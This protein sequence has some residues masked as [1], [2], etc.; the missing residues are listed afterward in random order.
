M[1]KRR[2]TTLHE[3]A[4]EAGRAKPWQDTGRSTYRKGA[5]VPSKEGMRV[6]HRRH[7]KISETIRE[8]QLD[9]LGAIRR[10]LRSH[11]GQNWNKVWSKLCKELGQGVAAKHI[12]DHVDA[13]VDRY[14]YD[15]NG[16]LIYKLWYYRDQF[17]VDKNGCLQAYKQQ[18]YTPVQDRYTRKEDGKTVYVTPHGEYTTYTLDS[19][20]PNNTKYLYRKDKHSPWEFVNTT[21]AEIIKEQH[22]KR[23]ESYYNQ[24]EYVLGPFKQVS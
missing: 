11:V 21:Q 23:R 24:P 15:A 17:Y 6:M 7:T 20:I 13:Y 14:P 1:T 8:R 10:W 19:D 2:K 22:E 12:R 9:N 5:D 3:K 18:K 4:I 16:K